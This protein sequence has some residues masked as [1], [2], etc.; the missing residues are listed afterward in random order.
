MDGQ[1]VRRLRLKLAAWYGFALPA[2]TPR[3]ILDY[4]HAE[5]VKALNAPDMREKLTSQGAEPVGNTP[6]QATAQVERNDRR[7]GDS[8]ASMASSRPSA[9]SNDSYTPDEEPF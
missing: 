2:K 9:P 8:G 7:T 6:E 3:P 5:L 4:Y 1:P